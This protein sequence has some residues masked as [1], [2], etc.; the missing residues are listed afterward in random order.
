MIIGITGRGGSGKSYLSNKILKR[1]KDYSYINVDNLVESKVLTSKRLIYNVNNYFNDKEYTI[2]DIMMAYFDKNV[3]NNKIHEFFVKEVALQI[4][5]E[6]DNIN[7]KNIIID[8][9]L[10]HEIFDYL[11]LDVRI[12]TCATDSERINRIKI[13]E[14][15]DE[16]KMFKMVDNSFVEID[17]SKIDYIINTEK[18]IDIEIAKIFSNRRL[19]K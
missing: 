15:C 8:W 12:M 19:K 3:K 18:D 11:P 9:F 1:Y 17:L 4:I 13:R 10:L 14:K 7:S 2:K 16:P 6:I 5:E